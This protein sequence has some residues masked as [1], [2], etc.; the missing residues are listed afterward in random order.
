MLK[1]KVKANSITNLTD[2]RY[3]AA[4]GVEWLSFN[5][6]SGA[7]TYITPQNMMAIK[8]WVDG[9][10][11]V[12]AFQLHDTPAIQ[13]A[14]QNLDLDYIQAGLFTPIEVIMDLANRP[15]LIKELII[16]P[17]EVPAGLNEII[18][19]FAPHTAWYQFNFAKNGISW[20]DLQQKEAIWLEALKGW[21]K[22]MNILLDLHFEPNQLTE[23]L[24]TLPQ[25]GLCLQGGVE[26]RVGYKSFEE[27]DE[28]FELLEVTD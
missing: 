9:V 14:I 10:K 27:L 11:I 12:G 17:N 24:A 21:N 4:W 16:G 23:I 15:P 19:T 6:D 5:F 25:A 8:E 28:I 22:D 1:T 2:A 7:D 13:Q 26:E 20:T 3:F 18:E